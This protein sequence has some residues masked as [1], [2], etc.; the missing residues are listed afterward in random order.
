MTAAV[1]QP[2]CREGALRA[3]SQLETVGKVWEGGEVRVLARLGPLC[4]GSVP[5]PPACA[6]PSLLAHAGPGAG[7]SAAEPAETGAAVPRAASALGC[8]GAPLWR[9]GWRGASPS[10]SRP[11]PP[12]PAASGQGPKDRGPQRV[13]GLLPCPE[14]PPGVGVSVCGRQRG[15]LARQVLPQR[16]NVQCPVLCSRARH[17]TAREP[18]VAVSPCL[19]SS[20]SGLL[21]RVLRPSHHRGGP[22][23]QPLHTSC[24]AGVV[25]DWPPGR[26]WSPV[27]DPLPAQL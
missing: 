20:G 15:A 1:G 14:Q 21:H 12:P 22:A 2:G 25:G 24:S 26:G 9:P 23:A 7:G 10:P 6:G 18:S 3:G 17:G 8:P 5:T 11:R 27:L 4:R 13:S 16:G 19:Q